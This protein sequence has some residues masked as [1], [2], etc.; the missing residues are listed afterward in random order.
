M[1]EQQ[2][3]LDLRRANDELEMRVLERTRELA[4][5]NAALE[6]S[7]FELQQFAYI[8]SHDLQAPLRGIAGFAQFLQQD[9][10][11]K[12]DQS[13]DEYIAQIVECAGRMQ[14]LISDLLAYSR[15]ESQARSFAP[16]DLAKVFDDMVSLL[17]AEIDDVGGE[18][19]RGDL[20]TVQ[21]DPAQLSQLFQHLIG[22]AIKYHSDD[23]P[24]IRV[25]SERNGGEFMIAVQDNGISIDAKH[26]ERIF[27]IFR[28][29]HTHEQYPGTGIGLAIC[30]RI[31]LRHGGR[32][33]V[34]STVGN[35]S[36]FFVTFPE[37][38][39]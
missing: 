38:A 4:A 29:L 3:E 7:N 31:V 10:R 5:S 23:L 28:R 20:P 16:T 22:N 35:G 19:V 34:E 25:T 14:R 33:W 8:V 15:L 26:H 37:L 12:L 39:E 1:S 6:Q 13:A 2:A 11:G 17:R 9:Y 32:I 36:T 30:R 21:G 27:E 18:V 24:R